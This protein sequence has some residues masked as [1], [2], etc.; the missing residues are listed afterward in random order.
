MPKEKD[1]PKNDTTTT[2]LP[3]LREGS[4]P[5]APIGPKVTKRSPERFEANLR[6]GPKE[7]LKKL[8]RRSRH[9]A[10]ACRKAGEESQEEEG[11]SQ[12]GSRPKEREGSARPGSESLI[13]RT[14]T[15]IMESK[16]WSGRKDLNLRPLPPQGSALPGCATPR[17]NVYRQTFG[18]D[19]PRIT[20]LLRRRE[21]RVPSGHQGEALRRWGHREAEA[22]F[23]GCF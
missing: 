4:T 9:R 19:H 22:A 20:P 17:Q 16:K 11:I 23:P 21:G 13:R 5:R 1:G 14:R 12:R 10:S 7:S 3:S 6:K 2:V 18:I 15:V 8:S